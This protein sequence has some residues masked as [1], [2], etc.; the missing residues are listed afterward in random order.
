MPRPLIGD[1]AGTSRNDIL[2][3]CPTALPVIDRSKAT[4]PLFPIPS[5]TKRPSLKE[6]VGI[7]LSSVMVS[8]SGPWMA[9]PLV[10]LSKPGLGRQ[11][12]RDCYSPEK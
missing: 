9:K 4:L 7:T 3:A 2:A 11:N 1:L 8:K 12:W 6:R 10:K 5:K